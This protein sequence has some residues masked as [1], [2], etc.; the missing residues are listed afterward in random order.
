MSHMRQMGSVCLEMQY[1]SK[2]EFIPVCASLNERLQ[3]EQ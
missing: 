3:N 1:Y 2:I